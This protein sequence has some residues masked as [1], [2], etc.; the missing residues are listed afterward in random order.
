MPLGTGRESSGSSDAPRLSTGE[1]LAV[2]REPG[3]LML[4]LIV[5]GVALAEGAANDW[6]PLIMVDGY[7]L[8]SAAGSLLYTLFTAAMAIGRSSGA[9]LIA[10]FG[11]TAVVGA[12][13]TTTALLA[14]TIAKT[15]LTPAA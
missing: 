13:A 14:G 2:W 11:R 7:E 12:S 1:R 3:T 15:A 4:G 9:F 10:R 5:L 8:S 6:L